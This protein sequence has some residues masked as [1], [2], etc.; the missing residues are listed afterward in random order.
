MAIARKDDPGVD[1]DQVI[2]AEINAIND[3]RK[4]L[5][6]KETTSTG[7][8]PPSNS[9]LVGL[10]FSGGGIRSA[11]FGLGVLEALKKK[12]LLKQV[13]YLSTVSGGGYIGAWLSANCRRSADRREDH[14][15]VNLDVRMDDETAAKLGALDWLDQNT[16]WDDSIRHLRRYSKYLSPE[17]GFFSA[18]TWSMG[19]PATWTSRASR[20]SRAPPQSGH[21]RYP[22]YRLRNTRTWTLYFLR[23]SHR[24]NPRIP[25]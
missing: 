24:K 7:G 18:D 20:R 9:N 12:G 8:N 5:G 2:R 11:T 4:V 17:V 1:A 6:R 21:V 13:D 3:R 14:G 16:K 15:K 25:S 19:R 23:S 10:A 22:R